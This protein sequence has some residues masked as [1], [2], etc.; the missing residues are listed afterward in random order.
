MATESAKTG[1]L[2]GLRVVELGS[3]IAGPYGG[4]LLAD[5]GAD[6]IKVEPPGS[7]DSMRAWGVETVDGKS[8]WWPVIGRN[9]RSVTLD[10]RRPEGQDLARRLA[11]GADVLLENFRP[12]TLE[13]WGLDPEDLRRERP[14]LV[15]ARVSGFGQTGPYSGRAGFASV[16]EAMGGLRNLTGYP[17]RPP[18]RVGLSIGDSLAGLFATIG[19]LAAL[20]ARDGGKQEHRGGQT[21]DV[22]ITDSVLALLESVLTEHSATGA[23]RQRVGTALPNLAPSNLYPTADA[24]WVIIGANADGPFRRLADAMGRKDLATDPRYATHRAR[25]ERQQELDEVVAAW[26]RTR[27]RDELLDL[28]A[29]EGVPAGPVYDAAD[30]AADPHFR[31]RG[32]VVDV[33]TE[34]FGAL[35]MQGI[36]PRLSATPGSIRWAGPRLGQHNREVYRGVLGLSDDEIARLEAE[37]II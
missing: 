1:P 17:D 7:G 34:E 31:E 11:L 15:V 16:A 13:G 19:V 33:P 26:T 14:G 18:T 21:V 6:V 30:V 28:L 23:I 36:A 37:G 9:K 2:A 22:A 8:L 27:P 20:Y 4:Q 25:G 10:L 29:A 3:F 32:A 35:A 12:G 24:S 5:L